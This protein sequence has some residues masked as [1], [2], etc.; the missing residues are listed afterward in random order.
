MTSEQSSVDSQTIEQTKQQIRGL[1]SEIAQLSKS[2]LSPA[3]Y[4]PALLQRIVDALAAVGGAI[5][6]FGEGRKLNLAYQIKLS[7]TLLDANSDETRRHVQLLNQVVESKEAQLVPPQ[8]GDGDTDAGNPTRYLLVLAPL[9]GNNKIEGIIEI[10]QRPDSQPA[11]QRGYLRFLVQMCELASDWMKSQKLKQF[12]DRHSLWAQADHYSR[13]VHESL[14]LRQSAY[15]AVNEGRRM[16]GCDRV[17]VAVKRGRRCTIEAI[18]GQDTVENRSNIVTYLGDLATKVVATGEAL[19]YEGDTEDLPPQIEK[20]LD[21]Y[22]DESYAKSIAVLP[23]RRPDT[24]YER[25]GDLA[26]IDPEAGRADREVIGALIVEQIETDI[27]REVLVPRIDLVYEHTARALSNCLHHN[28]LFLMPIWRTIG[29]SRWMVQAR[30]L[31]KTLAVA[32]LVLVVSLCLTLVPWDFEL[33]SQGTLQPVVK[34]D[35]FSEVGGTVVQIHRQHGE[36]VQAGERLLTLENYDLKVE[37]EKLNGQLQAAQ[38]SLLAKRTEAFRQKSPAER[39]QAMSELKPIQEQIQSLDLQLALVQQ[40]RGRLV[41]NSPIQGRV[42]TWDVERLLM[43]RTVDPSQVLLTVAD[44]S[45]DWELE[46]NMPERRSGHLD[47]ARDELGT[48]GL[49]VR[50]VVATDP[51]KEF[52]GN[53]AEINNRTDLHDEEGQVVKVQVEIET[54]DLVDPRPGAAVTAKVHC[55]RRAL[56]YCWFHEMWEWVELNLLF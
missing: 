3:E 43:N 33:K 2:E 18:S 48:E 8:S 34:R 12:S 22:I 45:K 55:G 46:L 53:I 25:T 35:V 40:K 16:I 7:E 56:G 54:S 26:N 39:A 51:K 10:F 20:S 30:T 27:P 36:Q 42:V 37:F 41:V 11:T 28:N 47:R 44:L 23:L 50:Y 49:G 14:D 24:S 32:A 38:E 9:Q 19:W 21:V 52:T 6:T 5:W 13:L 29:Y 17:S 4:Y 31:P 15:T 1:V